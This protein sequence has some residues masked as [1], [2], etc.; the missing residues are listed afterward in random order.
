MTTFE[1]PGP[2]N[3]DECLRLACERAKELGLKE[4][5]VATNKG[6]TVKDLGRL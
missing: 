1:K 2:V 4:V 5:I 3:T 6:D